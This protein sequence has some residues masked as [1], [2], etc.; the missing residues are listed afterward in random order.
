MAQDPAVHPRGGD[1]AFSGRYSER[2]RPDGQVSLTP[3]MTAR[4]RG[5]LSAR[6]VSAA[7]ATELLGGDARSAFDGLAGTLL[8][9][10]ASVR[11]DRELINNEFRVFA[12][13]MEDRE[14]EVRWFD[15]D[16]RDEFLSHV[17][18]ARGESDDPAPHIDPVDYRQ[19]AAI[20]DRIAQAQESAA[21]LGEDGFKAFDEFAGAVIA[22]VAGP[23]PDVEKVQ[24]CLRGYAD[25]LEELDGRVTWFQQT[26]HQDFLTII[27][28]LRGR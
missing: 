18:I 24:R 27:A 3:P 17:A 23:D 20:A 1:P 8:V 5:V 9:T 22:D 16:V 2:T 28:Q 25:Q 7:Q 15:E 21:L 19:R 13:R 14:G 6:L 26:A 4:E 11:P 10:V 12:D